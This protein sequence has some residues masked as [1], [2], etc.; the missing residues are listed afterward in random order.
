MFIVFSSTPKN[1]EI[2]AGLRVLV[3]DRG[4]QSF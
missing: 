2:V 1:T 3:G 4:I